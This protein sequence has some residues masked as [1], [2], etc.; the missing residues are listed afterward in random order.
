MGK[1]AI[2]SPAEE[3]MWGAT[4]RKSTVGFSD[5]PKPHTRMVPPP[6]QDTTPLLTSGR[7]TGDDWGKFGRKPVPGPTLPSV[8]GDPPRVDL[9]ANMTYK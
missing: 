7:A 4:F 1:A 8:P 3:V 6:V 9:Y 5:F 2:E